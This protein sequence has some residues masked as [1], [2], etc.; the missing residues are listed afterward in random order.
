MPV[1]LYGSERIIGK[2]KEISRMNEC[3]VPNEL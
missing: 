3:P 2:E 1:L